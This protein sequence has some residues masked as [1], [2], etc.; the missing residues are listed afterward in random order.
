MKSQEWISGYERAKK[1]WEVDSN[2]FGDNPF[3]PG[4]DQYD[5]Y[6]AAV[7]DLTQK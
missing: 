1:E 4:C 2:T 5:G 3:L 7:Y 6:E